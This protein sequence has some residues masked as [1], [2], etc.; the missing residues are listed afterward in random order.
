MPSSGL[1]PHVA[2]SPGVSGKV[3]PARPAAQRPWKQKRQIR[4]E[5]DKPE[6]QAR[7][8]LKG[9]GAAVRQG[10]SRRAGKRRGLLEEGRHPWVRMWTPGDALKAQ[11]VLG[12]AAGRHGHQ[13]TS[14][15]RCL[16]SGEMEPGLG[17][18]RRWRGD[19]AKAGSQPKVGTAA[20]SK[21]KLL[22]ESSTQR[23][24][25]DSWCGDSPQGSFSLH[26]SSDSMGAAGGPLT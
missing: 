26:L 16:G 2:A 25:W 20:Q 4:G 14:G 9:S 8:L 10:R 11:G 15:R 23:G 24:F 22:L 13:Q 3:D 19:G 1:G 18:W 17:R 6:G 12:A 5:T 7:P 21:T